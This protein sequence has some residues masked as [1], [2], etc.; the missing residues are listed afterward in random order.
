MGTEAKGKHSNAGRLVPVVIWL[1]LAVACTETPKEEAPL[2]IPVEGPS[3]LEK[4]RRYYPLE[5][6]TDLSS[7]PESDRQM[8]PLL[9]EACGYM[10]SIFWKQSWPGY[11]DSWREEVPDSMEE[12]L[13]LNYGPYD[14]LASFE[15]LYQGLPLRPKGA[16]FYP[17]TFRLTGLSSSQLELA[18][19]TYSILQS[20]KGTAYKSVPYSEVFREEQLAAADLLTRAAKLSKSPAFT[21]YLNSLAYGLQHDAYVESETYW[22]QLA[23]SRIDLLLGPIE[24]YEDQLLGVKAAHQACLMLNR[25]KEKPEL[26]KFQ[27][28]RQL[29]YERLPIPAAI[30]LH[31]DAGEDRLGVYDVLFMAGLF[32]AGSKTM[33]VNLPTTLIPYEGSRRLVFQNVIEAKFDHI[34]QPISELLIDSTQ[35]AWIDKEAFFYLVLFHE[36]A[37]GLT[38][39]RTLEGKEVRQELGEFASILEE[40]QGDI[41]GLYLIDELLKEGGYFELKKEQFYATFLASALRSVRFGRSSD[42]ARANMLRFSY[43]QEQGAFV[44]DSVNF[45]FSV[46]VDKMDA[47]IRSLTSRIMDL[48]WR[49]D[50][51]ETRQW[52]ESSS[53]LTG[54]LRAEIERLELAGIPVDL[55][56]I[57]GADVLGLDKMLDLPHS[58]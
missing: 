4:L 17:R 26:Q 45:R 55:R 23:D 8:L 54:P 7:L 43:F 50:L 51:R 40:C 46:E 16:N 14:R 34:L 21:A 29:L 27:N 56:F 57:Q 47:A 12:L 5:L 25:S 2:A 32:N 37:H 42:H 52:V 11:S 28:V 30:P 44:Y 3:V 19:S 36:I 48:Q 24:T 31:E 35:Q 38:V 15:P 6:K 22:L 9:L 13:S 41:L 20:D 49:G 33:G 58:Q 10:D 53:R 18:R 39:E 1:L